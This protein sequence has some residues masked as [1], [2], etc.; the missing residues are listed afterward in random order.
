MVE[1]FRSHKTPKVALPVSTWGATFTSDIIT[2]IAVP[3][4]DLFGQLRH[5][6]VSD[7]M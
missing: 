2:R 7:V 1:W 5:H 3:H 4:C 6:L